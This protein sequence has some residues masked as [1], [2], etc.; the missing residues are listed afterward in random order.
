M[1]KISRRGY[2]PVTLTLTNDG[3]GLATK[4]CLSEETLGEL[5]ELAVVA[6]GEPT[7]Y[8]VRVKVSETTTYRFRAEYLDGN[9][10]RRTASAA[11]V[12]I[13]I[14]AGGERP[15]GE[16]PSEPLA[17]P[18]VQR[19]KSSDLYL[20][21]LAGACAVLLALSVGLMVSSRWARRAKK[22]RAAARRQRVR[23]NLNRSRRREPTNG[24]EK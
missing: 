18:M 24:Q 9:G 22:E 13:A 7:V 1:A 19:T 10:R 11:E 4:V 5:T 16:K 12:E 17:A 6:G 3:S 2:V 20:W 8:T 23:E 15:E 21:L 14:G